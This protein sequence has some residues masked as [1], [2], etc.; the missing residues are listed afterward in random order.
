MYC[1]TADFSRI[2]SISVKI[3]VLHSWLSTRRQIQAFFFPIWVLFHEHSRITG[4]Q[5]KGEGIPLTLYIIMHKLN[6][7]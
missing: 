5:G 7:W 4:L 1:F 3:C 2:S 6:N